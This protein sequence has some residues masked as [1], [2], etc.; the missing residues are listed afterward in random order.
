ME[1]KP[2]PFCGEIPFLERVPLWGTYNNGTTHGYHGCFEYIIKCANPECGCI[3]NLGKN[4]TIYN[5]DE[6][7]K[8][9]AIAAWNRRMNRD[10][11]LDFYYGT[12]CPS[13]VGSDW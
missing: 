2:C 10:H 12:K 8:N 6:D 1:L 5:S 13:G 7:A 11:N 4:N 3:V 9:S